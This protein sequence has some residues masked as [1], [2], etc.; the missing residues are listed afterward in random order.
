MSVRIFRREHIFPLVIGLT[1]GILTALTIAAGKIVDSA[2]PISLNLAL[3][4]SAA[5][6]I[7]G[8]F[9]FFTAE[10][11]RRRGELVHVE[12]QLSLTKHG[13]MAATRLGETALRETVVAAAVSSLCNL[14]GALLPLAAGALLPR[15]PWLAMPTAAVAL[16]VLGAIA[17]RITYGKPALWAACLIAVGG[18]LT[19][20]GMALRIV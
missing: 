2:E 19:V 9:V 6:S 18:L 5:S 11:V 17:G 3:R 10:Y 15:F 7:S 16:G 20:A 13:H 1:D 4:I 14:A 12:R 8:M